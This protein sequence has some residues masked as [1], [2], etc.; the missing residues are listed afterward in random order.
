MSFIKPRTPVS[1]TGWW[2]AALMERR[3]PSASRVENGE[4]S[5]SRKGVVYWE[6][7]LLIRATDWREAFHKAVALGTRSAANGNEAFDDRPTFLGL[8]DLVPIFEPFEDG[9][10]ILWREFIAE[11]SDEEPSVY[12]ESE[13]A[14]I[15]EPDEN[16][17]SR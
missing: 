7:H 2:L 10:E 15:Y 11:D 4:G 16:Q 1:P 6:N 3:E 13:L 14:D 8:T 17:N 5:A 9:S 12:T